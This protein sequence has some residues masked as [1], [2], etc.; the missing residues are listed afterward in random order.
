MR[1]FRNSDSFVPEIAYV[2]L[3]LSRVDDVSL[4]CRT[5]GIYRTI[6]N[7]NWLFF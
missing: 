2:A 3:S 5:R 7:E 4:F 6:V 1:F